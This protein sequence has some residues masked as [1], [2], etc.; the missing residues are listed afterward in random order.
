MKKN[1]TK[2]VQDAMPQIDLTENA[3]IDVS[4][5]VEEGGS[6]I[7]IC[8]PEQVCRRIE[9][10]GKL[11]GFLNSYP[12]FH[13]DE[14]GKACP[15][16]KEVDIDVDTFNRDSDGHLLLTLSEVLIPLLEEIQGICDIAENEPE[17]YGMTHS[18]DELW[19]EALYFDPQ[20]CSLILLLGS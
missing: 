9:E 13:R 5:L 6:P 4:T 18:F 10:T 16:Y 17:V 2:K 14:N 1:T 19:V 8:L 12:V 15:F 7:D 20:D 3:S 11:T